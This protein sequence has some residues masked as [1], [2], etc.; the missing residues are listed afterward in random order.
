ME[1]SAVSTRLIGGLGNYI[2]QIACAYCYAKKYDKELI[3]STD[4]SFVGHKHLNEY[5]NNILSN[6]KFVDKYVYSGFK[7]YSEK[8]FHFEEIP[9]IEGNVILNGYWQT[10]KYW[11]GYEKEVKELFKIPEEALANVK[12]KYKDLLGQK[13]NLCS[14]HVRRGDYVGLE[15]YHA[16][17]GL[18]YYMKAIKM[19]DGENVK[20]VIFSDDIAF[21]RTI[22]PDIEDKFVYM[23]G[24]AD[25]E[26]IW[27]MGQCKN[28]IIANSTF[29]WLSTVLFNDN[30]DKK[31]IIPDKWFGP[32]YNDKNTKDLY[33]EGWIRI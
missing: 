14:V 29:S 24:N 9:F 8:G 26:E 30:P 4:D 2:L 25:F 28:N 17:Q 18:N 13:E 16:P 5:K 15:N 32:A 20:F 12:E 10:N 3:L 19:L 33:L 23:E 11:T 21:C 27:L 22:F 6:I 1:K 31:V 7:T